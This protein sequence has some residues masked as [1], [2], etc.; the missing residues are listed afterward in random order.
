MRSP[1]PYDP[2]GIRNGGAREMLA[3]ALLGLSLM[4]VLTTWW[5]YAMR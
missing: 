3:T 1:N 4:M 2:N 5:W